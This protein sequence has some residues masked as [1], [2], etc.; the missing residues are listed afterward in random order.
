[1]ASHPL[2][3]RSQLFERLARGHAE[4]VVVLTPNRR[5]SQALEAEFD[6]RQVAAGLA[7]WASQRWNSAGSCA[8]RRIFMRACEAPQNSAHCPR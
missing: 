1:M 6:R 4:R 8:M 5:L 2:I 7:S 3:D